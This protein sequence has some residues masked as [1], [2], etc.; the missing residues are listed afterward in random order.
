MTLFY[1]IGGLV[2][3][4]T[5]AEALVRGAS[6]LARTVGL[7]PLI[8]GLTI[9]AFGTSAPEMAVSVLAGLAGK[10]DISLGNVVGSNIFNVLFILGVSSL[11]TP[12][13]VSAQLVRLDVPIM[14][15]VSILTLMLGADGKIGRIDGILL[16]AGIIIYT[17]FLIHQGRRENKDF[18]GEKV[19]TSIN[20]Q[21]ALG[22]GLLVNIGL[23]IVGLALLVLGSNWLVR[24]AVAIAQFLGVSQL[25]IGLTVVAAGTSLPEVATSV[26]AALRG[27]RDIAVGNVVGSNIFNIMAVLGMS[28]LVASE[29]ITISDIT[30][31]FDIP[32]MTAVAVACLPIF[33]TG[34]VIS[35]WEGGLFL[36]YYLTYTLYLILS[37]TR[38]DIL[39]L[40]GR[41]ML[42]FVIPITA[43]TLLVVLVRA[44]RLR[45]RV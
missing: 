5:G 6:K 37:A 31:R 3:M 8:I 26:V 15:A 44:I 24:G 16:F 17:A 33:F 30:L 19:P 38:S 9:V 1:F 29:G 35:R 13:I 36:G 25:L 2:L 7:S 34:N 14:V 11:I 23:I 28:A 4:I 42:W 18:H 41:A 32:I 43:V 21:S 22:A 10:A 27:E 20:K 12:L 45:N 40:F 39:P